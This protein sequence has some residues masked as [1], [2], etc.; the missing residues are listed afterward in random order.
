MSLSRSLIVGVLYSA[1]LIGGFLAGVEPLV[2]G[3][4][5]VSAAY[6]TWRSR[7][8]RTETQTFWNVVWKLRHAGADERAQLIEALEPVTL[9]TQVERV[10]AR[11]GSDERSGDIEQFPFPLSLRRQATVLYWM[12]WAVALGLLV[13]SALSTESLFS[14]I[15]GVALAGI[16]ALVA[17]WASKREVLLQSVLEITPFRISEL[18]PDGVI[19]TLSWNNY[20][21]LR[22]EPARSRFVISAGQRDEGIPLDYRRMGFTRLVDRVRTYGKFPG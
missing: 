9:R 4:F 10:L 18:L 19:R 1:V 22:N 6:S 17:R 3:L 5:I 14:R 12:M 15:L 20:L 2:L 16:C 7:R 8:R 13:A 11:D 21:E